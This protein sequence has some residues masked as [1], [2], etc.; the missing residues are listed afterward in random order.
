MWRDLDVDSV[1]FYGDSGIFDSLDLVT[2]IID[3]EYE[4]SKEF[5]RHVD[6][7]TDKAFSHKNSPF[8]SYERLEEFIKEATNEHSNN[9][10]K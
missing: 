4:L 6:L 7:S 5:K 10:N 9:R 2:F 8:S 3:L 1:C